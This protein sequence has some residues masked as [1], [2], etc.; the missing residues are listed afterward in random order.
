M[1]L[2]A[3]WLGASDVE[4][5]AARPR[6]LPAALAPQA[7]WRLARPSAR[8]GRRGGRLAGI[9]R[10]GLALPETSNSSEGGV[11]GQAGGS[12]AAGVQLP[13]HDKF[14]LAYTCGRCNARN[15]I[16]VSR[17]A[18]TSGVVVA[19]CQACRSRHLMADNEGVLGSS[20]C[21][22]FANAVQMIEDRGGAV[23][24]LDEV[25]DATL[26][27]LN[28]TVGDD[29]KLRPLSDGDAAGSRT[30]EAA[31]VAA[32]PA[33]AVADAAVAADG[34]A[35]VDPAEFSSGGLG[36][37]TPL[38]PSAAVGAAAARSDA[39]LAVD[40]VV[41]TLPLGWQAGAVRAGGARPA[42]AVDSDVGLLHVPVPKEA[43]DG[44]RLEVQGMVEIGLG[45][46]HPRWIQASGTG[47]WE[48]SESWSVGDAVAVNMP[49]GAVARI[50]IPESALLDGMLR[51]G[52]PV[53]ILPCR[54]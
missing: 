54:K 12:R 37:A 45:A 33:A 13:L 34:A 31:A 6:A 47:R 24:R 46:G 21:T 25:D 43:P 19:T 2:W 40:P 51:I 44:S 30:A 41:V 1:F 22:G 26:R 39:D 17:I 53:V 28:L 16:V 9:G 15:A 48:K 20:N 11:D 50:A 7:L 23:T 36:A 3:A 49:E 8:T 18:W 10:L 38:Q 32:D 27:A 5:A 14:S 52:Y 4:D 29:G 35:G 42:L